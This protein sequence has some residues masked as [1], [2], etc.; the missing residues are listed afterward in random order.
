VSDPDTTGVASTAAAYHLFFQLKY[1]AQSSDTWTS[2][3]IG[4][5]ATIIAVIG[6]NAT[7]GLLGSVDQ[8]VRPANGK[9]Y[10]IKIKPT[11]FPDYTDHLY[12]G[13]RL[14][15]AIA[16]HI[17]GVPGFVTAALSLNRA[18]VFLPYQGSR[19]RDKRVLGLITGLGQG[20]RTTFT[21]H[22]HEVIGIHEAVK[23]DPHKR[24]HAGGVLYW[25]VAMKKRYG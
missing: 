17:P 14:L 5:M 18:R 15:N 10:A 6:R 20:S 1:T 23:Y 9:S 8:W 19:S 13:N 21:W 11:G 12:N 16:N 25:E 3:Q 22:H 2:F 7:K 24:P 4:K